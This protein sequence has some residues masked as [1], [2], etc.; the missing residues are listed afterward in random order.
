MEDGLAYVDEGGE[1][2]AF[3]IFGTLLV[4][5]KLNDGK[6]IRNYVACIFQ[7]NP[8]LAIPSFFCKKLDKVDRVLRSQVKS[9]FIL[10]IE[11]KPVSQS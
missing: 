11:S 4:D 8:K 6:D 2:V 5:L 7:A 9:V 10:L 1:G 3:V